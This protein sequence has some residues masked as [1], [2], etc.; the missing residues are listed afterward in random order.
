MHRV[1]LITTPSNM[2]HKTHRP[3]IFLVSPHLAL[4]KRWVQ[5]LRS[6]ATQNCVFIETLKP[7]YRRKHAR[8]NVGMGRAIDPR[9]A[10]SQGTSRILRRCVP[11]VDVTTASLALRNALG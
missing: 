6:R 5:N 7:P 10:R 4:P 11:M 8:S 9:N 1:T 2:H 3:R